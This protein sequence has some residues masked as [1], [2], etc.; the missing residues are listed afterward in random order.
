MIVDTQSFL[1]KVEDSMC[2]ALSPE[3]KSSVYPQATVDPSNL[4]LRLVR[5]GGKRFRAMLVLEGMRLTGIRD[6]WD[7]QRGVQLAAAIELLHLFGLLQDDVMDDADLRRGISTASRFV[8]AELVAQGASKVNLRRHSDAL[9]VLAGDLCL[10][11]A[12][13]LVRRETG[14][15]DQL[16]SRMRR[17]M[18][19]GQFGDVYAT[20]TGETDPATLQSIANLKSGRYSVFLPLALGLLVIDRDADLS[21]VEDASE[22]FGLAFQLADDLRDQQASEVTG[23]DHGLD[24]AN[25]KRTTAGLNP[26]F[27]TFFETPPANKRAIKELLNS[28]FETLRLNLY[29]RESLRDLEETLQTATRL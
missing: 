7:Y 10:S 23:K 9:A 12:D 8:E 29:P 24:I 26:E 19:I 25:N 6:E 18:I 21:K 4:A 17:E 15:I 5:A 13:D 27:T 22:H 1:A 11:T 20:A 14:K 16:W 3:S 28:G 2:L